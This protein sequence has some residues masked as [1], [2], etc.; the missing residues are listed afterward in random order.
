MVTDCLNNIDYDIILISS[1]EK[2]IVHLKEFGGYINVDVMNLPLC[3]ELTSTCKS[4]LILL[5]EVLI[6]CTTYLI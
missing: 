5:S 4:F 2:V 3:I 1:W 6:S